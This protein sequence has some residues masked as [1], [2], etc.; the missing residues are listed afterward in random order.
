MEHRQMK[1]ERVTRDS[2]ADRAGWLLRAQAERRRQAR[3]AASVAGAFA[4]AF[5]VGVIVAMQSGNCG[6]AAVLAV[7][8]AGAV[9]IGIVAAAE[10]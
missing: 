6:G 2:R 7:A 1:H 8:T 10:A 3:Q 4:I 9:M 5:A